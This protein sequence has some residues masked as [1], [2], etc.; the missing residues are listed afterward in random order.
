MP[1]GGRLGAGR[2]LRLGPRRRRQPA[3]RR[4][5][6]HHLREPVGDRE[7]RRRR[8]GKILGAE[9]VTRGVPLTA[10]LFENED[11]SGGYYAPDGQRA[12]ARLPAL[13]GRVPRDQLRVLGVAL[14]SHPA[15]LAS[16]Q[17]RRPRRA[18]RHAGASGRGRLGQDCRLDG[19]PR[20]RRPPRARRRPRHDVRPSQRAS[21]PESRRAP[22]SS[23]VR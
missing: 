20:P 22:P 7:G 12:V 16:A 6:P 17:G 9:I 19:W 21:P 8:P 11:G 15:P 3:S 1:R 23:R 4:R 5:V 13:S 10:V 18:A 14:P 2:H